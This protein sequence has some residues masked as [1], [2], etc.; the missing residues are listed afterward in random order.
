MG[1]QGDNIVKPKKYLIRED[2]ITLIYYLEQRRTLESYVQIKGKLIEH[3]IMFIVKK[4]LDAYQPFINANILHKN[5]NPQSILLKTD[6][7]ITVELWNIGIQVKEEGKYDSYRGPYPLEEV[8]EHM[9]DLWSIRAVI[10]FMATGNPPL[11]YEIREMIDSFNEKTDSRSYCFN[12]VQALFSD[13]FF[14]CSL[15]HNNK[16]LSKPEGI[17]ERIRDE[18]GVTKFALGK[19]KI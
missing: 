1:M 8:S 12:F 11:S 16:C 19:Y 17:V 18:S 4:L 15:K 3:E 14:K 7:E 10:Y 5:I 9:A 6:R 13:T 2:Q